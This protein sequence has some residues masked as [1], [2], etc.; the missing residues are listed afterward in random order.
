VEVSKFFCELPRN[1]LHFAISK[2]FQNSDTHLLVT[3][4][5][6]WGKNGSGK[7]P[8]L[9][10]YL[11]TLS[12]GL[13]LLTWLISFSLFLLPLIRVWWIAL[14]FMN[15]IQVVLVALG[16][17]EILFDECWRKWLNKNKN[18]VEGNGWIRTRTFLKGSQQNTNRPKKK[19][20]KGVRKTTTYKQTKTLKKCKTNNKKQFLNESFFFL[21]MNYNLKRLWNCQSNDR[22][23]THPT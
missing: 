16:I 5:Q 8:T 2:L 18:F 15:P 1:C 3:P 20:W 6:H 10:H 19:H 17:V 4:P 12:E 21:M 9:N 7:C 14:T 23:N 22:Q 11:F 13:S